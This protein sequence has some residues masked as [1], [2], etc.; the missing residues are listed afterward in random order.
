MR[1]EV[2]N[3]T[4]QMCNCSSPYSYIMLFGAEVSSKANY[5]VRLDFSS[6]TENNTYSLQQNGDFIQVPMNF[7]LLTSVTDLLRN[8]KPVFFNWSTQT[9]IGILSTSD[10]PVGEGEI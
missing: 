4:L 8:E 2:K 6:L 1:I 9:K 5:R 3:Y 7:K 10:E